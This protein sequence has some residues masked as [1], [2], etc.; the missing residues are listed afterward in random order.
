MLPAQ[1]SFV[2]D[3]PPRLFRD[4]SFAQ[5]FQSAFIPPTH[6][7]D[8]T[9]TRPPTL[10]I[11]YVFVS[12][13]RREFS[14]N[15]LRAFLTAVIPILN[16]IRNS[17]PIPSHRPRS[18]RNRVSFCGFS[19]SMIPLVFLPFHFSFSPYRCVRITQRSIN[20][21]THAKKKLRETECHADSSNNPS[22]FYPLRRARYVENQPTEGSREGN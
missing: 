1:C 19:T 4:C 2:P 16:S 17:I 18:W 8:H 12:K 15:V 22:D 11:A 3:F 14:L 6:T 13:S 21:S 10:A 9:H 5:N 7:H 20:F